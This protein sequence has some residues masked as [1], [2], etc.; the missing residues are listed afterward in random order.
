MTRKKQVAKLLASSLTLLMLCMMVLVSKKN[1]LIAHRTIP[2]IDSMESFNS[3]I[4]VNDFGGII[5]SKKD[6][7]TH[8]IVEDIALRVP[9]IHNSDEKIT[10]FGKLVR[11]PQA[12]ATILVCHGLMTEKD[13][14][15]FLRHMF[16][17]GRYNFMTFD[18][19]AHG[20]NRAGQRCTLGRD[21]ALDVITAAQFLKYHPHLNQK[22][23]IVYAF[24]MGAVAAIEAQAQN[25]NCFAAMILDCP[26]DSS[27]NMIKRCLSNLQ[28]TFLGY[29][30]AMPACGLLQKYAFHPYVQT[31][32]KGM[33][34]T[35]SHFDT[36]NIDI[37]V[38]PINPAISIKKVTVPCFFIHCKND[39]KIPIDAVKAIYEGASTPYKNLLITNGRRHFD[40]YFYNPERYIKEVRNFIDIVLN[41]SLDTQK[42]HQII[43]DPDEVLLQI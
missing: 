3:Y 39:E 8:A 17:Q 38:Y 9:K 2:V 32:I 31:L 18:F 34:K 35:I 41:N 15:G 7:I 29:D 4:N 25:E 14:V 26:F 28:F 21:E 40:S 22:P 1:I 11:Y 20:E 19:R 42:W 27:E 30:F 16:P 24:S 13:D 37:Q 6:P 5:S 10:R 36:Q 12:K 23:V 33:L 43:E